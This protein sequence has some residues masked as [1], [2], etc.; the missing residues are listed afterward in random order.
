MSAPNNAGKPTLPQPKITEYAKSY[1]AK[2]R[3]PQR[4]EAPQ[5]TGIGAALHAANRSN[6]FWQGQTMAALREQAKMV[7]A[8]I[9]QNRGLVEE[10]ARLNEQLRTLKWELERME[11]GF[12]QLRLNSIFRR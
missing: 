9:A 7:P 11:F 12:N 5:R 3:N 10:N 2:A 4:N 6:R 8:L 1:A